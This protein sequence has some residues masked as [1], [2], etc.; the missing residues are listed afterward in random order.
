MHRFSNSNKC[1]NHNTE[2]V[3]YWYYDFGYNYIINVF[4]FSKY[5]RIYVYENF[6]KVEGIN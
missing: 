2:I 3:F 6:V 1:S 5:I 4:N